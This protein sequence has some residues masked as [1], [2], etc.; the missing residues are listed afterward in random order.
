MFSWHAIPFVRIA[1]PFAIGIYAGY[2]QSDFN[3]FP[4]ILFVGFLLL[5]LSFE[6]LFT[7]KNRYRLRISYGIILSICAFSIAWFYTAS[8]S[9]LKDSDHFSNI[10]RRNKLL[11]EIEE[12][13]SVKPKNTKVY[14][15]VL[16]TFDSLGNTQKSKGK[17]LIYLKNDLTSININ[18][19]FLTNA[20]VNQMAG[21]LN[22]GD[23]DYRAYLAKK[24]IHHVSWLN[25]YNAI[26]AGQS[27]YDVWQFAEELKNK[28]NEIVRTYLKTKERYG[29]AEA[30]L[31]GYKDDISAELNQ[32]F[33]RTGT[34]HVLAVS[35]MHVG[36]IFMILDFIGRLFKNL[37]YSRFLNFTFIMLGL[38]TYAM[39]CGLGASILRATIMFSIL[40]AGKLINRNANSMNLLFLSAFVL[41]LFNPF[42]LFDPGFQ[43]SFAAVFG[44][45]CTYQPLSKLFRFKYKLSNG[46]WELICMSLSAQVF[47]FPISIYYFHQFPNYFLLANLIIIPLT[48]II[49]FGLIAMMA[50]SSISIA[51]N[52]L[53]K[54]IGYLIEFNNSFAEWIGN[55]KWS[56]TDNLLWGTWT[57]FGTY[58][59]TSVVLIFFRTKRFVFINIGMG[60]ILLMIIVKKIEIQT[61]KSPYIVKEYITRNQKV[62]LCIFGDSAYILGDSLLI[63]D[64]NHVKNGIKNTLLR[65]GVKY[66]LPVQDDKLF[67]STNFYHIPDIGFQ[68]FDTFVTKEVNDQNKRHKFLKTDKKK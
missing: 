8:Y 62:Q 52:P 42:V 26:Y 60:I 16:S 35:G 57:V 18:S 63:S 53:S 22:I 54:L 14:A 30:L 3:Y 6:K 49:L 28:C 66:I 65:Y 61:P 25:Q 29:I 41:M 47:T 20:D 43:L 55:L 32:T 38:W 23:F 1:L 31:I 13:I 4:I 27:N 46:I 7:L 58:V 40:S 48:S 2:L 21:P 39:I 10:K 34:L 9:Q 12:I 68:F 33:A 36:L 19:R 11:I 56:V 59:I 17:I 5:L 15:K 44:I 50:I 51:A 24:D 64:K 37:K 45:L 67:V